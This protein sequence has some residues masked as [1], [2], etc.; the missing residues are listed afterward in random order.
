MV[1]T[2]VIQV[3]AILV[4][5]VCL[6]T[7][8]LCVIQ[9]VPRVR[10]REIRVAG[11]TKD[12]E[13]EDPFRQKCDVFRLLG[14]ENEEFTVQQKRVDAE[15]EAEKFRASLR[16]N[17]TKVAMA[18]QAATRFKSNAKSRRA[19]N[20]AQRQDSIHQAEAMEEGEGDAQGVLVGSLPPAPALEAPDVSRRSLY[21][22]E[23]GVANETITRRAPAD[24]PFRKAGPPQQPQVVQ[25][26]SLRKQKTEEYNIWDEEDDEDGIP[27]GEP[28]N[29]LYKQP[30]RRYPAESVGNSDFWDDGEEGRL[31]RKSGGA[32]A[33]ASPRYDVAGLSASSRRNSVKQPG[34]RNRDGSVVSEG[35]E[36]SGATAGGVFS[37]S[38]PVPRG[39][40][41]ASMGWKEEWEGWGNDGGEGSRG[42]R[43]SLRA[44]PGGASGGLGGSMQ[45]IP[46]VGQ[47]GE[48]W[49]T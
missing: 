13:E 18:A 20:E 17:T 4:Y 24:S 1:A 28:H 29:E 6:L 36:Q 38:S 46:D 30:S 34:L 8:F 19:R 22:D 7:L 25:R 14:Y 33:V 26:G 42:S 32:S 47:G 21:S 2:E 12:P 43:G 39:G 37:S 16:V 23:M 27:G 41:H 3:I 35:W 11:H 40:A 10:A 9:T 5:L 45:R 15:R 48:D 49:D 31:T 44:S